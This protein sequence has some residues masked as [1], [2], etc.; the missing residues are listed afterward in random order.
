MLSGGSGTGEPAALQG[1]RESDVAEGILGPH[2][3][4]SGAGLA[5][6]SA[7]FQT[8]FIPEPVLILNKASLWERKALVC[9]A[10]T[11]PPAYCHGLLT[12]PSR[13]LSQTG[14]PSPL[15]GLQLLSRSKRS[16]TNKRTSG[17]KMS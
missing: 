2:T 13:P 5:E 15:Q 4:P 14:H 10:C 16:T 7:G 11:S 3:H 17:V 8:V 6:K 12:C 1:S 9:L